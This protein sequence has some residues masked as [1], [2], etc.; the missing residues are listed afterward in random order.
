MNIL[1]YNI[2]NGCEESS[3]R[4]L[5]IKDFIEKLKCSLLF[6]NEANGFDGAEMEGLNLPYCS[7]TKEF[8]SPF[9]LAI[10]SKH[11]IEN[12]KEYYEGFH[13]AAV[14]VT[15][16]GVNF[17][18]A[19]LNPFYANE[20]DNECR[21]LLRIAKENDDGSPF[22]ILGDLNSLDYSQKELYESGNLI[23][24]LKSSP[25]YNNKLFYKDKADFSVTKMIMDE[26]F[27]DTADLSKGALYSVPTMLRE[28]KRESPKLRLDYIYFK[29]SSKGE[30]AKSKIIVNEDTHMLSDHYP[31]FCEYNS[32]D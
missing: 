23:E 19:H 8:N 10:F 15:I 11:K 1:Q 28:D 18:F 17:L 26:G 7:I 6:L 27:H 24:K 14:F 31:C 4:L 12:V 20:R 2:Y 16:K 30:E 21:E 13:H 5:R 3:F 22:F 25:K 29:P 9:K 32:T